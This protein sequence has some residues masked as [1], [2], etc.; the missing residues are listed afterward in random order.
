M[1]AVSIIIPVHNAAEYIDETLKS[2]FQQTFTDYEVIVVDDGSDDQAKL[3][4]A[5]APYREQ[6]VCLRQENRGA[7]AARNRGI[8]SA[9]ARFVA[10]LDAD[11][12]WEP[13]FLR[14]Q[15]AFLEQGQH[16]L[17]Y[18]D[19][20][21]F[22]DSDF[23][24]HAFSEI[25]PS[26]GEVDFGSLISGRCN[27]LTSSVVAR[28]QSVIEAGCFDE[29]LRNGQD[30]DLWIRMALRGARMVHQ[31]KVLA[32]Y[33]YRENSL[34][35]DAVNRVQRELR[36]YRKIQTE[37]ELEQT[38]RTEVERAIRRLDR[39]LN[40]VLGKEHLS[41]REFSQARERFR[42]ART[43]ESNWKIGVSVF[44]L[45]IAPGLL[46]ILDSS[47]RQWRKRRI[48]RNTP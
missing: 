27:V 20:L 21:L 38:Q 10:F 26:T 19:G 32:R 30:F 16:D 45:S 35:G 41:R 42:Q 5:L 40:L 33:R 43:T 13:D 23:A 22:G 47:L 3:A 8:C 37:Y 9:S 34:S 25:A 11:D 7:G 36:V 24:G 28:R 12:L 17:A 48:L 14:Q 44:L 15:I 2:V 4:V 39:E 18:T 31:R 29:E 1:P 6:I 46:T